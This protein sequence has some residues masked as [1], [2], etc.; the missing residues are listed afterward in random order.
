M[1]IPP[2]MTIIATT[3]CKR[4]ISTKASLI[5]PSIRSTMK[6]SPPPINHSPIQA[7]SRKWLPKDC[8]LI[9]QKIGMAPFFDPETGD[10]IAATILEINNVEVIMHRT[11]ESNGYW[12][13]QVGY[14]TKN[15]LNETR[16]MLGH[17]ASKLINPKLKIAEF[18][19]KESSGLLP[20]GTHLKPSFFKVGQFVDLKSVS[21]GK[22]FAGVM[23]KYHFKGLRASHGTSVMHRHGGSYGQNQDPGR[24]LPGKKM[25]GRMGG[26]QVT[27]QNAQ[28]LKV[29]DANNVIWV[30]G[31]IPGPKDTFVK[32]QEA[33]KKM[34]K[35]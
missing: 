20:L 15:Y 34:D 3:I 14:G 13:N 27:V 9:G 8:G 19:V 22:G 4:T 28:I 7:F 26:K 33:I 35:N 5:A 25:P 31:S 30:K 10:R 6:S 24:I 18:R 23:K 2:S 11:L 1:L 16:Q 21:K 12:A 32:I 29:D 17:F